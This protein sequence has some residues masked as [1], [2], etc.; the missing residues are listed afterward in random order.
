MIELTKFTTIIDIY[1]VPNSIK[2]KTR[3]DCSGSETVRLYK[4]FKSVMV[5]IEVPFITTFTPGIGNLS[6]SKT[7]PETSVVRCA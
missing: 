3:T 7:F 4:P 6:A 5:P 2:E 1:K